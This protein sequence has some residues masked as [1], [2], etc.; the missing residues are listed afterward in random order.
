MAFMLFKLFVFLGA[1]FGLAFALVLFLGWVSGKIEV[2]IT[3]EK[4]DRP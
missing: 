4:K 3:K 2:H 1:V